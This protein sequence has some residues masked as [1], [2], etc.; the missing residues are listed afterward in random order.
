MDKGEFRSFHRELKYLA[1][2]LHGVGSKNND[3]N[4]FYRDQF[5]SSGARN[6]F[7]VNNRDR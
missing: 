5:A 4:Y 2:D 7:P 1:V 6:I 3:D